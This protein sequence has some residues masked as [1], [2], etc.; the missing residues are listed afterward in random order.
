MSLLPRLS[1]RAWLLLSYL[2]VFCLPWLAIVGSGALDHD[3]RAQTRDQLA[4]Q[5]Q[6]WALHIERAMDSRALTLP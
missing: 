3:L 4:A 5:G 1:L 6:L 2:V